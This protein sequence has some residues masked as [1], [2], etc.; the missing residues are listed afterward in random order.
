[1]E[2]KSKSFWAGPYEQYGPPAPNWPEAHPQSANVQRA[3]RPLPSACADRRRSLFSPTETGA[4]LAAHVR[5]PPF[6][7]LILC[8]APS[9][10]E[11]P[12]RFSLSFSASLLCSPSHHTLPFASPRRPPP[13][14]S[15]TCTRPSP[16]HR[17]P[18][19]ES[20]CR[21]MPPQALP[22]RTASAVAIPLRC[23]HYVD[24]SRVR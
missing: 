17:A 13:L 8:S 22:H 20:C 3:S 7:G 14:P 11:V 9:G 6:H 23:R 16:S 19:T 21:P 12:I 24:G 1:M 5:H 4:H 15:P 2:K 10:G 18:N